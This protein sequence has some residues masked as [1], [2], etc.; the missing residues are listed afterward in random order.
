MT[1]TLALDPSVS[2]PGLAV[3]NDGALLRAGRIRPAVFPDIS[4]GAR[5]QLVSEHLAVAAQTWAGVSLR[6]F[7]LVVYERPQIYRAT[8]SKGDPN[9]LVALAAIGAAVTATVVAAGSRPR[10]ETPTPA[11]WTGQ[12]P[13]TTRGK[14]AA[15]TSP[16][17]LRILSRLSPEEVALVPAQHDAIDAVGLGLHALGRLGI[18]RV[19]SSGS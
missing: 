15:K 10:I 19:Y 1:Y 11:E 7:S 5:W 12:I 13:K 4:E 3:F 18:R 6:A 2:S 14:G 9:D 17:A 16:R 8:K